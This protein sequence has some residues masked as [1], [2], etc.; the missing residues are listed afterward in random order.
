MPSQRPTLTLT[1]IITACCLIPSLMVMGAPTMPTERDSTIALT[2]NLV[3][4]HLKI[5]DDLSRHPLPAALGH[6]I[7]ANIDGKKIMVSVQDEWK[8]H[9]TPEMIREVEKPNEEGEEMRVSDLPLEPLNKRGDAGEEAL[10]KARENA[11]YWQRKAE[12]EKK[13]YE[14][15]HKSFE[16][17]E[18]NLDKE[19]ARLEAAA[20]KKNGGNRAYDHNGQ[21]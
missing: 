21:V 10:K 15:Q 7:P 2:S 18:K 6:F 9:E 14:D 12:A 17:Q 16:E 5:A 20:R 3:S 19:I 4:D 1:S 13:L 11:E 8:K